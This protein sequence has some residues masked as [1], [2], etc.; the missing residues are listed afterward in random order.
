MAIHDGGFPRD[1]PQHAAGAGHNLL[2]P[3]DPQP[4]CIGKIYH[5]HGWSYAAPRRQTP[6]GQALTC[7]RAAVAVADCHRDAE[8]P[9]GE[10]GCGAIPEECPVIRAR[11]GR[12]RPRLVVSSCGAELT[13]VY[14]NN[15]S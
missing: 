14:R 6:W 10:P 15:L 3:L 4:P 13:C 8:E 1:R 9:N 12:R 5:A 7:E 11:L 2:G